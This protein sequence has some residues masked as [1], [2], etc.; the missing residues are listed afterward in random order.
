MNLNRQQ[1]LTA[2]ERAQSLSKE[3][4]QDYAELKLYTVFSRF[5]A[6][7]GQCD[8]TT[9]LKKVVMIF[10]EILVASV[11]HPAVARGYGGHGKDHKNPQKE[12]VDMSYNDISRKTSLPRQLRDLLFEIKGAEKDGDKET[13]SKLWK[14]AN[15]VE[16][17]LLDPELKLYCG[18]VLILSCGLRFQALEQSGK[19]FQCLENG[20][21]ANGL[22]RKAVCL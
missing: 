16:G 9:D 19:T 12:R 20:A 11:G 13:A 15:Q 2:V 8:L 22:S 5:G 1:F 17:Q 7:S 21:Y 14:Q 18:D 3:L 10:P 6:R 4:K